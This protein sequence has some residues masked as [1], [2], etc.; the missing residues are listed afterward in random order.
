VCAETKARPLYILEG[1]LEEAR[2]LS[3]TALQKYLTRLAIRYSVAVI[4]TESLNKTKELV[5]LLSEQIMADAT[6]F[7][8]ND[9][10]A[11]AYTTTICSKKRENRE[12][13]TVFSS[14]VLQQCP[15]VSAKIA[16]A[17]VAEFKSLAGIWTATEAEMAAV[18]VGTRKVGPVVAQRLLKL[19]H[20]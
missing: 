18:K 9:P 20:G 4:W 14:A 17:L 10:T 5:D 7:A 8:A 12:D 13:P 6:V 15:G 11:V 2:R 3:A 19:L 16:D 1:G